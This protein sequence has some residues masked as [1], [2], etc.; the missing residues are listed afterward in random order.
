MS[1]CTCPGAKSIP[2]IADTSCLESFGQIQKCI[3]QRTL[4]AKGERISIEK[5]AF[6]LQET[7]TPLFQAAD[8]TKVQISPVM[9]APVSEPGGAISFG[10]GNETPDGIEIIIGSNPTS[11]D[12]VFRGV[13]QTAIANMKP[14]QCEPHLGVYLI[15]GNGQIE[16][17]ADESKCYPIPI[18]SFFVSDKGHGGFEQFDF[19][20]VHWMFEPNYSDKLAIIK[21]NF[22]PLALKNGVP[23]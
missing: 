10:G 9:M 16:C 17:L 8:D 5:E 13:N 21:P 15:D 11:F 18:R 4:N 14:L 22:N 20:N 1:L 23:L 6:K 19:N 12:A 7:W 2:A 3:F